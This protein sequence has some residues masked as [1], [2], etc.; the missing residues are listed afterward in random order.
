MRSSDAAFKNLIDYFS[1]Q[2][3]PTLVVMFGDHQAYIEQAFYE[4]LMQKPL[5]QWS[6][7]ELLKA[8]RYALCHLGKL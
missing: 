8:L 3:E 4:E 6:L 5:D 2:D 7:E 1:G